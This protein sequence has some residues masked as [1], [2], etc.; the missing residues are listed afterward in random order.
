MKAIT[1]Y[2][3]ID[4][5]TFNTEEECI[6]YEKLCKKVENIM[7]GLGIYKNIIIFAL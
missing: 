6:K 1:K 3:A 4:K 2:Q 5:T 7:K